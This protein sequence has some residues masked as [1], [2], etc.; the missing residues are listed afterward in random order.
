MAQNRN[1]PS[2]WDAPASSLKRQVRARPVEA[3]T[4]I[5]EKKRKR[6]RPVAS[7]WN[8]GDELI[9]LKIG[10]GK[11]AQNPRTGNA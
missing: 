5:P 8:G 10:R 3:R 11:L 2:N 4:K 9:G 6:W 7:H 1:G